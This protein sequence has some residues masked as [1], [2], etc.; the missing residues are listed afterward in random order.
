MPRLSNLDK[1]C[2]IGQVE[3]GVL[4]YQV[5][6]LFGVSPG[7]ISKLKA[8]FHETG[9]VKDR[10]RSGHPGKTTSEEDPFISLTALICRQGLQDIMAYR[11]L[12]RRSGTDCTQPISE[13]IC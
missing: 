5:A 3:A 8:K 2:A 13:L 6:T 7:S 4:Q 11:S 9:D 12:I 10:Q 1:A